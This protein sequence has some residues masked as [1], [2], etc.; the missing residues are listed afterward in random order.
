M[1]AVVMPETAVNAALTWN[2]SDPSVA[3]VSQE[4]IVT[5]KTS[6]KATITVT[7]ENGVSA[8]CEVT[9]NDSLTDLTQALKKAEEA[10]KKAEEALQKAEQA[11]AENKSVQAEMKTLQEAVEAA[12]KETA[13]LKAELQKLK[14]QKTV[15]QVEKTRITVKK[16]K[17]IKVK[18]SAN[19]GKR[20]TYKSKNAKIAK[21]SQKGVVRGIKK[22]KTKIILFC[23]G[24]KKTVTVTVK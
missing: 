23:N 21:V 18:A 1:K 13:Y 6:G 9:V 12:E 20:I 14:N 2:S 11:V 5:G 17:K 3:E 8:A 22:G 24:V 4:G 10:Q 7:A 19:D 16:G 15:L